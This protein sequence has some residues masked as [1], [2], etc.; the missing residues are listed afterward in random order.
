MGNQCL[1]MAPTIYEREIVNGVSECKT[2][3]GHRKSWCF[4][5]SWRTKR[6]GE[7]IVICS[8]RLVCAYVKEVLFSELDLQS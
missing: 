6:F 5:P 3:Q 1:P 8:V 4:S 7:C 2:I